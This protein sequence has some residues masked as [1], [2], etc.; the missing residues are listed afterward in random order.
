MLLFNESVKLKRM[1]KFLLTLIIMM[2]SGLAMNAEVGETGI[3]S[4]K[5]TDAT[6]GKELNSATVQV[7][8]ER[9]G[10]YSDKNGLFRIKKL[11][12]GVYTVTVSY[13]GY[14]TRNIDSVRVRAG[15]TTSLDILLQEVVAAGNEVVVQADRINDN[16]SA[17][18][19]ERQ[20]ASSV[21]DGVAKEEISRMGDGDAGQSVKRVTGVTLVEGKYVYVRGVSDRYSNTTLN[22]A[23]L[24]TTEPDKK[25]FAFDMF[26]AELL[27]N[28]NVT[29]SFTPDLPGNFVGGLVQ[30]NTIDFPAGFGVKVNLG[31]SSNDF[32]TNQDGQFIM[33]PRG[34]TDWLG[35]DDGSRAAPSNIPATQRDFSTLLSKVRGRDNDAIA[36]WESIGRG[37][38]NNSWNTKLETAPMNLKGGISLTNLL[39]AGDEGTIGIVA[40]VN[41]STNYSINRIIRRGLQSNS[42]LLFDY[43]GQQSSVESGLSGLA[44]IAYRINQAN[45]FSFKNTYNQTSENQSVYL[46]GNDFA[47]QQLRKNLSSEFLQKQ[48]LSSTLAGEHTIAALNSAALDWRLGYSQSSR[49]QP[50]YLRLRYQRN[51][52]DVGYDLEA[53]IPSTQ[54]GSG[55][56][57][58]RFFSNLNEFARS[59]AL[60]FILPTSLFKIKVGGLHESKNRSFQARSFTITRSNQ[61]DMEL[62]ASLFT[63]EENEIPNPG[64]LFADSNYSA[65]RLGI[66][67][68][69]RLRDAYNASENLFAYYAM[70]EVPF[71]VGDVGAR[72]IAG[73][74]VEQNQQGL[75][76][77]SDQDQPVVVD[78]NLTDVLPSL[79]L[80][81]T[82]Q[83]NMNIRIAATQTLSRPSLREFAPFAFYDYATQSLVRGNPSLT[84]ALVQNYDLRWEY[85]ENPGEVL[86]ASL[87][88]K[89]FNNAIEETID[90]AASEIIRSYKNAQ[91][92]AQNYGIELELRKN[93]GFISSA[94]DNFMFNAN[95]AWINSVIEV[96]QG[97][98]T[99]RRTMWGQSP[100]TVNL[101]LFYFNTSTNTSITLGYNRAGKKIV[102][103]AQIGVFQGTN[104]PHVYEL[105]R[106]VID[107]SIIQ[108]IG[109]IEIKVSVSD[110]LNQPLQWEQVGQQVQ[111]NVRGRTFSIGFSHK[112]N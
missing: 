29:K 60:N 52:S 39:E 84:R 19:F 89:N 21:S 105:P 1:K 75:N 49:N 93:L 31:G 33:A 98:L 82:P 79:N 76:S 34:S 41:Y 70:A 92:D 68:D 64:A 23:S 95:Y 3:I 18:L 74:R 47:Q 32:V 15:K 38:N 77:F 80:I 9:K 86:S 37:F 45:S 5:V 62:D 67:E 30:L 81:L 25:S 42:E 46:Y 102:Q 90:P 112:F 91:G 99:D 106:D 78:V 43:S 111:S 35:M 24:T 71:R 110:L 26:P 4:G 107:A 36:E 51:I 40:G 53:A 94:L 104:N 101:G 58:G 17:Q 73:A 96:K 14:T 11:P 22:G 8:S 103:V 59:A 7:K 54:Q 100:Y 87:F 6:T 65:T 44:N 20:S 13:I 72:V 83:A 2:V 69:S 28:A 12:V 61:P 85:F 88:Y 66:S 109:G 16:A 48:L 27:Q 57:A 50:D 63:S 108:N 97:S 10:A 56:D 55:P